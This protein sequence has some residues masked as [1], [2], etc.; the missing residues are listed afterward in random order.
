MNRNSKQYLRKI[1]PPNTVI[2]TFQT[3]HDNA[4]I[5]F[6]KATVINFL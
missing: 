3:L 4:A 5:E 2:I 1:L 6:D